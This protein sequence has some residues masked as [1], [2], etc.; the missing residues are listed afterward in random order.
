[1]NVDSTLARIVE[2]TIGPIAVPRFWNV[3]LIPVWTP[4]SWG[5][6][7]RTTMLIFEMK[8]MMIPVMIG[9]GTRISSDMVAL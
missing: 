3:W 6:E 8:S 5:F 9:I 2:A 4:V 1:M 7:E